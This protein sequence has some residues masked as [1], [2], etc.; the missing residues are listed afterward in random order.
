MSDTPSFSDFDTYVAENNIKPDE[1]GAAFAAFLNKVSG[2]DGKV[3]VS[4]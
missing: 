1:L 3:E 4:E 2:W